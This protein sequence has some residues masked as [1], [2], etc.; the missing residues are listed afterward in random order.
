MNV[1]MKNK[2]LCAGCLIIVVALIVLNWN[3]VV[4]L[5]G[6]TRNSCDNYENPPVKNATNT[7]PK[8]K[9]EKVEKEITSKDLLPKSSDQSA[10]LWA[11]INPVGEPKLKNKNFLIGTDTQGSSLR[12][13]NL[14]LRADPPNPRT[15]VSPWMNSTID[16]DQTR[17]TLC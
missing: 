12:N 10:S 16:Q 11:K 7:V 6:L 17:K 14:Q 2:E 3:D 8:V 15:N 4:A 5:L 13:A 1:L 9:K